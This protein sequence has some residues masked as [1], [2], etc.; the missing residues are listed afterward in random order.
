M[1]V[2]QHLEFDNIIFINCLGYDFYIYGDLSFYAIPL[3]TYDVMNDITA[4]P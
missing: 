2:C 1:G 4:T 3:L